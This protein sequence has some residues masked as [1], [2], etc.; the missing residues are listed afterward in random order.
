VYKNGE[1]TNF[2]SRLLGKIQKIF[3]KRTLWGAGFWSFYAHLTQTHTRQREEE[4]E[5]KKKNTHQRH[6]EDTNAFFL[7]I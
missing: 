1:T 5:R 2:L 4:E 3:K 7:Y 6:T